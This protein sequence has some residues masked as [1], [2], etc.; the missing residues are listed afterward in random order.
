MSIEQKRG[1]GFRRVH[2]T[3]LVGL[4]LTMVCDRLPIP[5]DVC[6]T[7]NEGLKFNRNPREI[8]ADKMFGQH[9]LVAHN[10]IGLLTTKPCPEDSCYVCRPPSDAPCYIMGVGE[11]H[12]SPESFI[13][14]AMQMGVS[15]RIP[16]IPKNLVV[17]KSIVFLSHKKA[18]LKGQD[19]KGKDIFQHGIF[20]AFIPQRVERLY[21]SSEDTPE[22]R[23]KLEKQGITAVIVPD[24]DLDHK[25]KEKE[26]RSEQDS[27]L[28]QEQEA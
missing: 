26:E 18:I 15:K 28:P 1:C 11:R 4:G 24:G 21:W 12:Y 10:E 17:G 8:N 3:Y 2:G 20:Y 27:S 9:N 6:P 13:T 5:L 25:P 16:A 7:C 23:E 14:E 19:D 22:L